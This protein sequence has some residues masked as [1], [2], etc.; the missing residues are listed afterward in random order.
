MNMTKLTDINLQGLGNFTDDF[1]GFAIRRYFLPRDW[2]FILGD[3][4]LYWRLH[5]NGKCYLQETP[6]GGTYWLRGN[7]EH[8][9][10][11][12]Q[13]FIVPD[14]EP[15]RAFTNFRGA[16]PG[17][18]ELKD[19]TGDFE[20]RLFLDRAVFSVKREGLLVQTEVGVAASLPV[21]LMKVKVTNTGSAS[22]RVVVIPQILPWLTAAQPAAWD[23]PWLYQ[24][25]EFCAATNSVRFE[26][27]NP[28]G[29][30]DRRRSL[31]W[32]LDQPFERLCLIEA[33]FVGR[34]S[35]TAPAALSDWKNW[36]ARGDAFVYGHP[37]FAALARAIT[38]KP[39]ESWEFTAALADDRRDV[40]Q[41]QEVVR[42][43]DGELRRMAERKQSELTKCSIQTPDPALNRYVNEHVA[44]QQ[45]LVL[46]RGWP[47]N[48]MGVRDA[49]QDYT[50]VV[51]WYPRQARVMILRI[52]ETERSDGWFVRQFSTD[53][54]KGKHDERPYVDSGLWVWELVYEYVCQTRDFAILDE[55][56][57]FLDNDR[58]TTVLDH[59][60]RLLGYFMTPKNLGEHGLCKILEGDWNDSVNRA[61]LLGRG[62]SVMVSCHLIYC[63]RQAARLGEFLKKNVKTNDVKNRAGLPT[64]Q[65]CL[66]FAEK[67]RRTVRKA[68][69]N[70]KGYL[71]GVFSDVGR[72]AFSDKD[73]DGKERFNTP[74][75][76]FGI[77]AGV[78][79]PKEIARLLKK[80]RS[81]RR[82]CG[83]P[84]FTPPIGE[85]PM[86]GLGRIG[87]GDL[88]P[89]LGENGTCYNHGCH[90]FLA[91]AL[92]EIGES[93]LFLDVMECLFPY[94]QQ[95]HPV[96]QARTAPY[97]IVNVYKGA[98]G[99]EGE[100]GDTFFSGTISVAVRNIYQGMLG[101]HAEPDGLRIRPCFPKAW[102]RIEGRLV[103]AG[104]PLHVV[105]TRK[106]R[107]LAI[108]VNGAAVRDGWYPAG[109]RE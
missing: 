39:G 5:H 27:R 51:G 7:G 101:V 94:D 62:E 49:A 92:A 30:P 102:E 35:R 14:G 2:D 71:N 61:G 79:E 9:V 55:K 69:L 8:D 100:G 54:R 75:N 66:A 97:A 38:L 108:E 56:L 65:R 72:W 60:G 91:R 26:M 36:T 17:D 53:G 44:L 81:I 42:N 48:M 21:A 74:V 28:A 80:V 88:R 103:Y 6:P 10:P 76:S 89:G 50:G 78:F 67:M 16:L 104:K 12:W 93:E 19:D 47:C 107:E 15:R 63:L 45:Q 96:L 29:F 3:E 85:P 84:L 18:V 105:V 4:H 106:G 58:R 82:D 23:M 25:S 99:R 109:G 59:L 98:P 77:I 52:L 22:R 24:S 32:M 1:A 46:F 20:C 70:R 41:L 83:Y 57:P 37:M 13:V 64:P 90:G 33:D 40:K 68:A 87:S 34:G 11:P 31:R 95:H 73:A 86:D 43:A